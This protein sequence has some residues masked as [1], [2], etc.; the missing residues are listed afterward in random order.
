MSEMQALQRGDRVRVKPE[1]LARADLG[2][3]E[4]TID[5]VLPNPKHFQNN[6]SN[7]TS[8]VLKENPERGPMGS[9]WFE[10][11]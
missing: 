10:K 3:Q 5:S 4:Y 6:G 1:N 2:E 11:V 7:L 9:D 8:V